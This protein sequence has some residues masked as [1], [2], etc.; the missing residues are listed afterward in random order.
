[1]N[2]RMI[3]HAVQYNPNTKLM[4]LIHQVNQF[5]FRS[6]HGIDFQIIG[7]CVLMIEIPQENRVQVNALNTKSGEIGQA[8]DN[9]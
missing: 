4:R 3:E 8:G 2:A 6:E 5:H 9:A 7:R 1:M